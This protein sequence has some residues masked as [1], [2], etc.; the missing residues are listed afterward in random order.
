MITVGYEQVRGSRV[1]GETAEA[2]FEVGVQQTLPIPVAQAWELLLSPRGVAVWLGEA[3]DIEF[4][5]GLE[6]RTVDGT[7]GEIRT[8][9]AGGRLRLTWQPAGAISPS[10]LQI[11]LAPSGERTSVRI[12]HEKLSDAAARSRLRLHW[13]GVLDA[14]SRLAVARD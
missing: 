10:T 7:H 14:L 1:L 11:S 13:R 8:V 9:K 12:H 6:Y 3:P 5:P 2:G 4:G